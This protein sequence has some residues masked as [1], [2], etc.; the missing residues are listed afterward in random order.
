MHEGEERTLAIEPP[1]VAQTLPP[2]RSPLR[3]LMWTALATGG[4]GLVVG[5][6]TGAL[7]VGRKAKLDEMCTGNA[8]PPA[9]EAT[10]GSYRDYK[11]VSTVGYLVGLVAWQQGASS[12]GR[13]TT[14]SGPFSSSGSL[15]LVDRDRPRRSGR[16]LK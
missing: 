16:L 10:L 12:V 2:S 14:T 7:A 9:A 3:P 13:R 11:T 15:C 1:P 5:I 8:C 6:V 4:A